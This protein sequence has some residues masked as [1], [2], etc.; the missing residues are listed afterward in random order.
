MPRLVPIKPIELIKKLRKF[1][2][3]GPIEWWRH[4]HMIKWDHTV[5]VPLHWWVDIWA[6]LQSA[7]IKEIWIDRD[8]R[9]NL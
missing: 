8:T 4:S 7:I 9:I 2:Y 3:I 1:W 5:P 6:W